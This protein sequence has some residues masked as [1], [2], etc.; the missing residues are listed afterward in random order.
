MRVPFGLKIFSVVFA[1]TITVLLGLKVDENVAKLFQ[2]SAL[3]LGAVIT[4]L[5]AYEAF[6]DHR[7]LWIRRTVT[8]ARLTELERDLKLSVVGTDQN[9]IDPKT[10]DKLVERYN[11]I[12]ADDL[13]AWL[14]MREGSTPTNETTPKKSFTD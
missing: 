7:S 12:L 10:L 6:Y 8:L 13:K 3:V 11:R 9:Q 5:N 1:A 2:N 4:V 14:R